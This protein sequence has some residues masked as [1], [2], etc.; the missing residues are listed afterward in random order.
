MSLGST[1]SSEDKDNILVHCMEVGG[2]RR[3]WDADRTSEVEF[4]K[5]REIWG[6][7]GKNQGFFGYIKSELSDI[8]VVIKCRQLGVCIRR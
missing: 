1:G 5:M 7:G 3:S 4:P 2:T 6:R 8:R